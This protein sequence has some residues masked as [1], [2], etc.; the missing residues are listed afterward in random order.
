[1]RMTGF[2]R[3]YCGYDLFR[4]DEAAGEVWYAAPSTPM[5]GDDEAL[6]TYPDE[7]ALRAA[8]DATFS[9]PGAVS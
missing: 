4:D 2:I 5:S 3:A 6:A 8:I 1:M 9:V 7:A